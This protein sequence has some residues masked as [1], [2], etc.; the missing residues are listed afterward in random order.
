[1][2]KSIQEYKFRDSQATNKDF[3]QPSFYWIPLFP[4]YH[5]FRFL[6]EDK[7]PL[8][9]G[10]F[11][12][13]FFFKPF[14]LVNGYQSNHLTWNFLAK[15]LWDIGFRNIFELEITDFTINV[16]DVYTLFD[17]VI[18][19]ILSFI[20]NF[21]KVIIIGHSVGGIMGR[22]YIKHNEMANTPKVS[23]LIALASPHYGLLHSLKHIES[24]FKIIFKQ[25]ELDL[26]SD[27]IGL[28]SMNK[29]N[30][31]Q[32]STFITMINVQGSMKLL[33]GGDGL[34]RPQPVS[35]MINYV[36]NKNHFKM[37]KNS[38]VV[39]LIKEFLLSPICIYKLEL[40]SIDF[41]EALF[42]HKIDIF[43]IIQTKTKKQ[44][45]PITKELEI[46]SS[47]NHLEIPQIIFAGKGK[48]TNIKHKMKIA[49][50]RKKRFS[51]ELLVE[52]E[53]LIQLTE[54]KPIIK[55][56]MLKNQIVTIKLKTI[57]YTLEK[58]I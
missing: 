48:A 35:E 14:L 41:P 1:M 27:E 58:D 53:I 21:N 24:V 26:F 2:S 10:K 3:N 16:H 6:G 22:Y 11:D 50:F 57:S 8:W 39:N 33:G 25:E 17:S 56:M 44:R 13:N 9:K 31:K 37:N 51:N 46:S 4:E 32:D 7:T 19:T 49:V 36:I 54:N 30:V 34:F 20:P 45:Y 29:E 43:F 18:N 15:R 47:I 12:R 5:T 28:L 42:L 38:F 23:M 40:A 52:K 55:T